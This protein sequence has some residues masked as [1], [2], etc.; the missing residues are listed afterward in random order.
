MCFSI[1]RHR[2]EKRLLGRWRVGWAQW[3]VCETEKKE[4]KWEKQAR[5][6]CEPAARHGNVFPALKQGPLSAHQPS[7]SVNTLY[8]RNY[9]G[10]WM[11]HFH[12]QR[13]RRRADIIQVRQK[14]KTWVKTRRRQR[15]YHQLL[16]SFFLGRDLIL[17]TLNWS[18]LPLLSWNLCLFPLSCPSH[19][20]SH[21]P[22]PHFCSAPFT[23]HPFCSTYRSTS[24][25]IC[26]PF[27][28]SHTSFTTTLLLPC[29]YSQLHPRSF[30]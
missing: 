22:I 24:L 8:K 20:S 21:I 29:Y 27:H 18:F 11:T 26:S 14:T 3:D 16:L 25:I 19:F 1:Y 23:S 5:S 30:R 7:L 12:T 6:H 13:V 2:K 9:R 4:V 10:G 28:V 17:T 15:A